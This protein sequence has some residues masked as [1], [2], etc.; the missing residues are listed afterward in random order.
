MRGGISGIMH[1]ARKMP[2]NPRKTHAN[3]ALLAAIL[4][5]QVLGCASQP[6]NIDPVRFQ[7]H[8]DYLASDELGGRGVGSEGIELAA[9]YIARQFAAAG[10][11]PAGDDG[12]FFQTFNMALRRELT[13]EAA[14]SFGS[15]G[16]TEV[17]APRTLGTDF[18][19]LSFSSDDEFD[20]DVVFCGYGISAQQDKAYD[21]FVHVD[22]SGKVALML[23][24]EPA[25]WADENGNPTPHAMFRN[26]VYNAKDR[27]AV[28]VLFVNPDPTDGESDILIEF[29]GSQPDA[30]GIPAMQIT[31]EL[32]NEVLAA[33]GL[34]SL[35]D[36]QRRLDTGSMASAPL[37]GVRASGKSGLKKTTA[38]TRNVVGLV[39]GKGTLADEYVVI[40][41]H[42]D[43]LGIRKPM[44]RV[45]KQGKLVRE[46]RPPAIHN[47]ADDNASGTSGLI[48]IARLFAGEPA[49]DRSILFIAFTA[50]ES[51]LHGSKYFVD[52]PIAPIDR[53]V[54]MLN[55][56]MIGRLDADDSVEVFGVDTGDS[57]R[58][59]VES[60]ARRLGLKI[61]A[62]PDAGGRSD[63]AAFV[64]SEIPSLHFFS[65]QHSDYH[66]PSDDSEKINADGGARI[67]ALVHRVA[68]RI[69]DTNARPVFQQVRANKGE[70]EAGG[71]PTYRVVMGLAPG[72]GD[73][74]K[75]GMPV[76]AVNPDG[77]AD[78]AGMKP[79]DRI[80]RIA[81]KDVANIYDYMG[82][83]R[84][85]SPGDVVE[86]VVL[87]GD[88]EV[89]L[90]VTLSS[91]R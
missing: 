32:A 60:T 43:H 76:D 35:N 57:F 12:T 73:D 31:R 22:L 58:R 67:A 56:D 25:S 28:A 62:S 69:A 59:S 34:Q 81:E 91:A 41:A 48:E 44:M 64:R 45:F 39:R 47:G 88:K 70:E 27:N 2:P 7:A 61:A 84:N 5:A 86:V 10:V 6:S 20:G 87:R 9:D 30:Y 42:Y 79:G 40:G 65:G 11:E 50:E 21:D 51:G 3:R 15:D 26:K 52:H 18:A 29:D 89:T 80:I 54:A 4:L 55:M 77:P 71:T 75:P 68:R 49:P 23:R 66:K 38:P 36:L 63:H 33:G 8:I 53:M 85:N 24:R 46:D 14:L 13:D 78:L 37:E 16:S 82:A 83:T 1:A 19:P 74:G 17:S 72:Y 90:Q